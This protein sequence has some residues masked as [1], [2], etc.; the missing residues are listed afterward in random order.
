MWSATVEER[1]E[2]DILVG[3]ASITFGYIDGKQQTAVRVY[4]KGKNAGRKNATTPFQQA[5]SETRR[6][7]ID[8]RDKEGYAELVLD[9]EK[10]G[11]AG[12]VGKAGK[13]GKAKESIAEAVA[14]EIPVSPDAPFYRP[15]LAHSYVDSG[16][17][18]KYPC[19]VQPKLDGL[20]C[21]TS[22][23]KGDV[24]FQS[25]TGGEFMCLSHLVAPLKR[26]FQKC[27][28]MI[29]DGELYTMEVPFE[30]LAG[31]IKRKTCASADRDRLKLVHYHI[32][33]IVDDTLPYRERLSLLDEM[34]PSFLTGLESVETH[35]VTG[36]E[37]AKQLFSH[38]VE[39]GYEGIM[40]RNE[41]GMYRCNY[42]SYDLQKYKEFQEEEFPI[43]GFTQGKGR[44][45]G[46]VIWICQTT[47][48]AEFSAR[49]RGTVAMRREWFEKA[50]FYIGKP[51]TVIFQG[52]SENGV[53]RFP[54]GKSIRV[55]F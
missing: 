3:V 15:M 33:D 11:K 22:L 19:F 26:I 24:R 44:D 53:P 17:K 37:E 30:E 2:E 5:V 38:F 20:R 7:W 10:A 48:G 18:I 12:K 35:R 27:P 36:F 52:T 47:D 28:E 21:I 14:A 46:T 32:Y 40:L 41:E 23:Y 6:K 31:L 39:N 54:V 8:K 55:G 4:D 13:A 51:L 9:D 29:L 50:A 45:E 49:P 16:K 43:V 42:R 25:R 1:L 34:A